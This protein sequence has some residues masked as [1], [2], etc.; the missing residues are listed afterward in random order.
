MG[1]FSYQRA[2]STA[3][4][5]PRSSSSTSSPGRRPSGSQPGHSQDSR[6]AAAGPSPATSR[7]TFA[8]VAASTA[9]SMPFSRET[10]PA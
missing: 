5:Q 6:D 7:R 1:A 8:L 4:R 9:V 2:G 10:R 3:A